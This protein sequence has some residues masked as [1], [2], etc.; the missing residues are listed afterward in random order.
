MNLFFLVFIV[1]HKRVQQVEHKHTLQPLIVSVMLAHEYLSVPG[2]RQYDWQ[3]Y[4]S[5][6]FL[7]INFMINTDC[8]VI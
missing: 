1:S 6:D 2:A 8:V 3:R 5:T 4:P 7:F